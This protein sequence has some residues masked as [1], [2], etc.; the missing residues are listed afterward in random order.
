LNIVFIY[1]IAAAHPDGQVAGVFLT[2]QAPLFAQSVKIGK[3]KSFHLHQAVQLPV[4]QLQPTHHISF[5]DIAHP[6]IVKSHLHF[7]YATLPLVCKLLNVK[8]P[9]VIVMLE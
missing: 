3:S 8:V 9:Q 4:L 6:D 1:K 5:A 7:M 2:H